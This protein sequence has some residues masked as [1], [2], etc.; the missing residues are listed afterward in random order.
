MAKVVPTLNDEVKLLGD[1]SRNS[2]ILPALVASV[3]E[4]GH[5]F[6]DMVV[7]Q[8]PWKLCLDEVPYI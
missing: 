8:R 5:W 1:V 2:H 6:P 3:A 7:T 4:C